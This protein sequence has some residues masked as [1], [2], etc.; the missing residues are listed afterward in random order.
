ML[1]LVLPCTFREIQDRLKV[2]PAGSWSVA[3]DRIVIDRRLF[4]SLSLSL[5]TDTLT[6][7]PFVPSTLRET[8]V[9]PSFVFRC[10]EFPPV[11]PPTLT[12]ERDVARG[13]TDSK[14]KVS[15]LPR[16]SVFPLSSLF[17][18]LLPLS[19]TGIRKYSA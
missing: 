3:H 19:R 12:K 1:R 4:L 17:S 2:E 13:P 15:F 8:P 14:R 11:F 18:F 6:R 5:P 10:Y 9:L 16:E 7:Q